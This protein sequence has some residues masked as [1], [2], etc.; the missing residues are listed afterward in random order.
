MTYVQEVLKHKG[1]V[2]SC[3]M[4]MAIMSDKVPL[5]SI[6][7]SMLMAF[8]VIGR[9]QHTAVV[10]L[11]AAVPTVLLSI[12][13]RTPIL[14]CSM[15]FAIL[16]VMAVIYNFST[17]WVYYLQYISMI[18][19]VVNTVLCSLYGSTVMEWIKKM[20]LHLSPETF[21]T[22]LVTKFQLIALIFLFFSARWVAY[23]Y[24]TP[25]FFYKSFDNPYVHGLY[26]VMCILCGFILLQLHQALGII[27]PLMLPICYVGHYNIRHYMFKILPKSLHMGQK[28]IFYYMV[29]V[30]MS[31]KDFLLISTVIFYMACGIYFSMKHYRWGVSS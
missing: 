16:T 4:L 8:V 26:M 15:E 23:W 27:A 3:V 20:D 14:G 21:I 1:I 13:L 17:Y 24:N 10:V 30:T 6:P 9:F 12:L 29:L 18:A 5:L 28:N 2:F 31:L 22:I 19:F 7:L 11:A 25:S